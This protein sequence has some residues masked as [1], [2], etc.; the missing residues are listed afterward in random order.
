MNAPSP[1]EKRAIAIHN[2][3]PIQEP[4]VPVEDIARKLGADL[5]YEAFE[6]DVSGMLF[7]DRSRAVIGVNS[8]H[9]P[10]RQRFTVAHECGH[11][12]MHKGTPMFID[13]FAQVNWR[14][15]ESNREEREANAFAAELLMPRQLIDKEIDR[16]ISRRR[17][18]TFDEVVSELA[19]RFRVSG[20]AMTYRLTNLGVLNPYSLAG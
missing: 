6:G 3:F 2:Q 10:T 19:K 8:R 16:V 12:L 17:D 14:D 15:G 5:T 18:V 20:Q 1:G 13:R 11:L 4:P 7:R 9:A